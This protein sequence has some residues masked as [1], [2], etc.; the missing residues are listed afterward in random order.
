MGILLAHE[1]GHYFV[2]EAWFALSLPVF[3]PAPLHWY[4][5]CSDSM[6]SLPTSRSALLE[7]GAAKLLAGFVLSVLA[8][9]IGLP[10]T[11]DVGAVQI[12]LSDLVV[13]SEAEPGWFEAS[14]LIAPWL[15]WPLELLGSLFEWLGAMPTEP[16]V[17][18]MIWQTLRCSKGSHCSYLGIFRAVMHH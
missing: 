2:Q 16:G 10:M 7:M 8:F 12:S 13:A 11:E 17:P 9:C 5:W 3:I 1:L 18:L 4:P 6:R 14:L 15:L